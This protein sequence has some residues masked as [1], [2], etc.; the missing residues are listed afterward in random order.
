MRTKVGLF[1]VFS[2]IILMIIPVYADVDYATIDKETFTI[3]DKFTISGTVSD[4]E[5]VTLAAVMKGPSGEKLNKNAF[6]YQ[7]EF[8]FMPIDAG[9]LFESKGTY[10]I[11][12]FTENQPS[13]SGFIIKIEYDRNG[14]TVLPNYVLELKEIGNKLVDE[15]EKL[16]FTASVTD[17]SIEEIEFSLKNHPSGATINK[18]TGAFSWTPTDTQSGGYIFDIVV[19]SGVLEDRETITVNVNDKPESEETVTEPEETVTEPEEL[20]I[21]APFVDESKD[22]QSYVDRYNSESRYKEWFD[23]TYPKYSSIYEA[24]GLE[25][26]KELAS[27]VDPNLD[28]QYYI[29]RYN[30]EITYKE[31]FDN[32]YSEIT[33]YEAVGL[34]EPVVEKPVIEEPEFGECGEGTKLIDG[35]CTIVATENKGGG[36]L[37]ATAAYGSEMAP[38]VQLLREIRDNQ[39][40][41]TNSG[42]LFM[43]GFNQLYYS[44]SPI[45]A[46]MQ[47]ENPVFKEVVKIGI[48]PLLSS[49]SIM[50]YAESESQ[51]L[52]YGIS[53]ILMNIGIY[54]VAPV[55]LFY[56]IRKVKRVRF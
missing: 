32:T 17:S 46:D 12:V 54:F 11:N 29:D 28:P 10:T 8:S 14:A 24:V 37:I 1:S 6:S 23:V 30:N 16:S 31:W 40:M 42:I 48:T 36:C 3:D 56:V 20:E 5:R 41:N 47:R 51:V 4:I 34:D 21:P 53:V 50:S 26:P 22:P 13:E 49:L 55:M 45:I 19:K 44:F 39:L 18:D 2:L 25:G 35:K 52:G 7:G 33:I 9:L 38:Q 43:T 15:T 27:F